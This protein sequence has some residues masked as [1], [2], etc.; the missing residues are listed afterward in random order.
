MNRLV[1]AIAL[2]PLTV[3]SVLSLDARLGGAR[4]DDVADCDR[5]AAAPHDEHKVEAGVI[6]DKLTT[7]AEAAIAACRAAIAAQPDEAR[8]K[9]QLG[10]ALDAAG[11]NSEAIEWYERVAGPDYPAALAELASMYASGQGVLKDEK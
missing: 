6:W 2:A 8:F 3:L 5:L 4:A 7:Q 1:L 9:Y 10:R 11:Q